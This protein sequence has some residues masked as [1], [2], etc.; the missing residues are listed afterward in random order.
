MRIGEWGGDDELAAAAL[1][2]LVQALGDVA[3]GAGAGA[4]YGSYTRNAY[5]WE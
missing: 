2:Q 5:L 1:G 3:G 4:P